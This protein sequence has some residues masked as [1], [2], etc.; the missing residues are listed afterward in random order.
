VFRLLSRSALAFLFKT[1][2]LSFFDT[3]PRY[4][5]KYSQASLSRYSIVNA[6]ARQI[7]VPLPLQ[8]GYQMLRAAGPPR[9]GTEAETPE[10]LKLCSTA[11]A[12]GNDLRS[13]A[14]FR[15]RRMEMWG[16]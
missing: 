5:R 14:D 15:F 8:F 1:Q 6:G 7:A 12:R 9:N 2:I 4:S 16:G 11:V 13:K 3:I 10:N